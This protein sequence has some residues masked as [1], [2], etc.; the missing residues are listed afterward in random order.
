MKKTLRPMLFGLVLA[1]AS[2]TVLAGAYED[3]IAR[4]Q[5]Q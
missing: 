2:G 1:A 3:L 5:E 4:W